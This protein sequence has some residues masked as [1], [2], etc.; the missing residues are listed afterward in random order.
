MQF[1]RPSGSDAPSS[2]QH[3]HRSFSLPSGPVAYCPFRDGGLRAPPPPPTF[4][5]LGANITLQMRARVPGS[6]KLAPAARCHLS[7]SEMLAEAS[8][9]TATKL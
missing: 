3:M 1:P 7:P 5:D 9:M 4:S 2:L 6:A 8:P